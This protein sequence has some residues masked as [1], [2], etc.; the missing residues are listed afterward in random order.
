[1]VFHLSYKFFCFNGKVKYVQI[2]SDRFG[3]HTRCFYDLDW[4]KQEFTLLYPIFEGEIKKPKKFSEMVAI[5]SKLCEDFI[6]VRIDLYYYEDKIFFGEITLH[7]EG[8]N[9]P[10][11]PKKYDLKL[12]NELNLDL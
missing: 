9:G 2:D 6:F 1:M 4:N 7:P 12:G 3:D 10:F 5:V 8:G 11:I